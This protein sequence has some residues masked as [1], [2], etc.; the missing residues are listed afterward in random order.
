LRKGEPLLR[1]KQ[2]R[3]L[4]GKKLRQANI[5]CTIGDEIWGATLD[6]DEWVFRNLALPKI[7]EV[8][9]E[10][11][12]FEERIRRLERFLEIFFFIFDR[13]TET[14]SAKPVWN[15]M[16]KEIFKWVN[17]RVGRI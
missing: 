2:I 16:Q 4:N 13:F 11:S 15:K 5:T 14:R 6:A 12:Y 7:E 17:E 10:T 9:D 8:M 3:L 1:W